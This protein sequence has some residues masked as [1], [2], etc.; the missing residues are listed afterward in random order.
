[1]LFLFFYT[2]DKMPT[3]M[4]KVA[5]LSVLALTLTACSFLSRPGQLFGGQ[6]TVEARLA[7]GVNDDQPVAVDLVIVYDAKLEKEL[8]ALTAAQWFAQRSQYLQV[9]PETGLEVHSWEW[10]PGQRVAARPIAYRLGALSTLIYAAYASEGDHRAQVSPAQNVF[11]V[12][13][14]DSFQVQAA[15]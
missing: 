10:V 6:A 2:S 1:M 5:L 12:F 9:S 14:E 15:R 4:R 13:S 7:E 8:L 3:D 11:L